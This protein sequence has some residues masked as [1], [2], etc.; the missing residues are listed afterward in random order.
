MVNKLKR[1]FKHAVYPRW[2]WRVLFPN[3]TLNAIEMAIKH[4][5]TLHDGELRFA[6]ENSLPTKQIW[7]GLSSRQRALE[8]FS[9]LR[10]WDTEENNGVLIYVLL[11]ER[12]VHIVADRGINKRVTKAQWNDIVCTMLNEF[13]QDEFQ[14]GALVGIE[15][16]TGLLAQ[17]F[18]ATA[19]H[20]NELPDKPVIIQE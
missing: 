14:R 13:R 1:W 3:T 10:I 5:E 7:R 19:G 11:A 9:K 4:S 6:I 2:R 12:S 16:I 18:P 15:Q 8:V 17:H 20:P